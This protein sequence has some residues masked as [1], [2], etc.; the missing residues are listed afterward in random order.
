VIGDIANVV[1]DGLYVVVEVFEI[2]G[3]I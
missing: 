3:A 1:V 2:I